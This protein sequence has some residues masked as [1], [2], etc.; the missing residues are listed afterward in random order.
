MRLKG[1]A[2]GVASGSGDRH[3]GVVPAVWERLAR[4]LVQSAVVLLMLVWL[5]AVIM[6]AAFAVVHHAE[7]LAIRL[8]EPLEPWRLRFLSS[9]SK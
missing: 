2:A 5:F 3:H 4:R 9:A 6:A 8:G 1:T 7:S